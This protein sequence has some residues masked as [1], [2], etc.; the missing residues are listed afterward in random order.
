V[1]YQE[2][3]VRPRRL[4]A[5]FIATAAAFSLVGCG[6]DGDTTAQDGSVSRADPATTVPSA[7]PSKPSA[8]EPTSIRKTSAAKAVASKITVPNGVGLNYQEAQDTWR[9]AGMHVAPATDATGA[10]RLPL[11]DAN[12]VVLSQDPKAGTRVAAGSMITAT[13]KKN[14]D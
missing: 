9:T 11:I 1:F 3:P 4:L 8:L 12:W 6:G 13:V 7:T 14:S 10:N 2:A 5:A